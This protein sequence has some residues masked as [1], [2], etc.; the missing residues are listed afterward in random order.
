MPLR[1]ALALLVSLLLHVLVLSGMNLEMPDMMAEHDTLKV[2]L[3][4]KPKL[5]EAKKPAIPKPVPQPVRKKS[6][7][8]IKPTQEPQPPRLLSPSE[9]I[10]V[11][12]KPVDKPTPAWV[13]ETVAEPVPKT[14]PD[15]GVDDGI[16]SSY[17]A[18]EYQAPKGYRRVNAEY[19]L[20]Y[21]KGPSVGVVRHTYRAEDNGTYHITA[22]AEAS[23]LASLFV[24]GKFVQQS[25]GVVTEH[26]LRPNLFVYSRGGD[27][28]K[29]LK[30][31]FNWE[32][33]MLTMESRRKGIFT[34]P[35]IDGAQDMLSFMYQ[36]MFV[37]PL[38]QMHLAI[39]NGKKFRVY[40]YG[41]EG[42]ETLKTDIGNLRT[43]HI[44]K[45]SID[46]NEKT[47]LWLAPDYRYLPVKISQTEE[48]GDL[49]VQIVKHL[50]AE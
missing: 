36:F 7:P 37:P 34:L 43:L 38:V 3:A 41:F 1:L 21:N 45:Y 48:D 42:E 9:P 12:A 28:A 2:V 29:D 26:G 40:S 20:F 17:V 24:R 46:G 35:L 44:A 8:V 18:E 31:A 27:A 15:P 13:P 33:G 32:S 4:P 49:V 22:T 47:E 11:P 6:K 16:D 39:T 50:E 10:P 23:G 14:E 25:D 30:A 19:R 5:V